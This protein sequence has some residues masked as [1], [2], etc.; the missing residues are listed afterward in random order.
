MDRLSSY[1]AREAESEPPED[2]KQTEEEATAKLLEKLRISKET[3]SSKTKTESVD[4]KQ[5]NGEQVNGSKPSDAPPQE[6]EPQPNKE[7]VSADADSDGDLTPSRKARG[8]PENVKLY[9]IFYEQVISLVT[10][11]RLPIQDTITLLVSLSKLA[12]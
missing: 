2:R 12:L 8:I 3:K 9:D 7:P 6:V 1:A 4:G 11:Q 5:A 10:A